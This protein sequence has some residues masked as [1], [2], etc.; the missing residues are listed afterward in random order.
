LGELGDEGKIIARD[1]GNFIAYGWVS[2]EHP[3]RSEW[4]NPALFSYNRI[5]WTSQAAAKLF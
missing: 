2:I 4:C 1:E 3:M 5:I